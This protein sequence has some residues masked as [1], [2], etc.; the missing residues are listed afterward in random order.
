MIITRDERSEIKD[1]RDGKCENC[2]KIKKVRAIWVKQ[3]MFG[4]SDRGSYLICYDCIKPRVFWHYPG[5]PERII[6]SSAS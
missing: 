3:Q 4:G 1:A 6:E 5:N 2:R